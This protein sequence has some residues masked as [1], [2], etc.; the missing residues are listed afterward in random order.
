MS[1]SPG[2]IA[3]VMYS[4]QSLAYRAL[5]APSCLT[6]PAQTIRRAVSRALFSDGSSTLNKTMITAI[7]TSNS[8]RVKRLNFILSPPSMIPPR[9]TA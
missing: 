6:F 9:R 5:S 2:S 8:T 1:T 4:L 3:G 7:T